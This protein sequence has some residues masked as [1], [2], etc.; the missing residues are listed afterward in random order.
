MAAGEVAGATLPA[1]ERAG[2]TGAGR[3]G[4]AAGVSPRSCLRPFALPRRPREG[5]PGGG[6]RAC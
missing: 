2:A 3:A 1:R 4:T 6:L 5:P